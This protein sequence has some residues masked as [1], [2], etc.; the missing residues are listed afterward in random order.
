MATSTTVRPVRE[1]LRMVERGLFR[2]PDFQRPF[3]WPPEQ[4]ASFLESVA[5]G[6][7]TGQ[8]R[9]IRKPADAETVRFGPLLIDAPAVP[10]ALWIIDGGQRL[11]ALMSVLLDRLD[12]AYDLR[13]GQVLEYDGITPGLL[14][15]GTL[16]TDDD[17]RSWQSR[18]PAFAGDAEPIR[19][20]F[21]DSPV[22]LTELPGE[23]SA[24]DVFTR[25][26]TGGVRLRPEDLDRARREDE[27]QD[28]P[29][30]L[31]RL[32]S[33]RFGRFS[34]ELARES[35]TAVDGPVPQTWRALRA[36]VA[37]L[38]EEA[39]VPHLDVWRHPELLAVLARYFALNRHPSA[40]ARILLRR[41]LWRSMTV[42]PMPEPL[43][44][45]ITGHDSVDAS[46]LVAA[47]PASPPSPEA[48]LAAAGD[49]L[50]LTTLGPLSL[51]TG[52]PLAV[53]EVLSAWG[54]EAFAPV[55]GE[56]LLFPPSDGDLNG[57]L[58]S[59]AERPAV[60]ASHALDRE[61]LDLFFAGQKPE[62][63]ERRRRLLSEAFHLS[64]ARLAA[65]GASDRPAISALVVSDEEDGDD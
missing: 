12:F 35:T 43:H 13:S 53:A 64:S 10:N 60:L 7:P 3:V 55:L 58:Q 50:A 51:A 31:G 47:A 56:P 17:F 11:T 16:A 6:I 9:A 4:I 54:Q 26:N 49:E 2:I 30:L 42:P 40:R 41:W 14:P 48:Y 33:L 62:F 44:N 36:A 18:H 20:R 19:T 24:P 39:A 38:R 23:I 32:N 15:L 52:A 8:G 22:L 57:A 45:A 61:S 28:L 37:W 34:E 1:V 29:S 5:A 63:H 27:P 25:I 21:L 46:R 65:W 59:A